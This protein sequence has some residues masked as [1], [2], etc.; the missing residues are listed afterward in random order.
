[1]YHKIRCAKTFLSIY[2]SKFEILGDRIDSSFFVA[3]IARTED[4]E[5]V[6]IEINDG[7]VA[8]LPPLSHPID[9]YSAVAIAEG[10][11]DEADEF[12]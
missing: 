5:L 3:D 1:M 10:D 11:L 4:G 2:F 8:G 7:G 9:F 12:Y 6:L